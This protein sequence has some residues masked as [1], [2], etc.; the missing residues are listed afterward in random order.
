LLAET[1]PDLIE[2]S[3]ESADTYG[4]D[5]LTDEGI[6]TIANTFTNLRIIDI[7]WNLGKN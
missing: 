3:V 5:G 6:L 4:E 2:I 7:S 1:G